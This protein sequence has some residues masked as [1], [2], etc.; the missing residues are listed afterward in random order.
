[1]QI[2]LEG[3][4]VG[5]FKLQPQEREILALLLRNENRVVKHQDIWRALWGRIGPNAPAD[6]RALI[7]VRMVHL[8]RKIEQ[9][10]FRIRNVKGVG[11]LIANQNNK[12]VMTDH[13][14]RENG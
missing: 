3:Y 1:M 5:P 7:I 8:R 6:P 11:Y 9:T 12:S 2:D 14:E 4:Q 10:S 13:M